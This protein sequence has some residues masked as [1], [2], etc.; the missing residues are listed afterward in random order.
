MFY[1]KV[2]ADNFNN[3]KYAAINRN[4]STFSP[5]PKKLAVQGAISTILCNYNLNG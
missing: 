2:N 1:I 5:I 3:L 4:L